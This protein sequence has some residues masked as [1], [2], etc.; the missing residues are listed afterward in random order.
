MKLPQRRSVKPVQRQAKTQF[1]LGDSIPSAKITDL[2]ETGLGVTKVK[3]KTIFVVGAVPGDCAT[4]QITEDTPRYAL[5]KLTHLTSASPHRE[6]PFCALY[7]QCGGCQLQHL[8]IDA[9]RYWK[10]QHLIKM[11][12]KLQPKPS[13]S[14]LDTPN[15]PDRAYR[16]RAKLIL[17]RGWQS[18]Q[19]LLGFRSQQSHQVVDISECPI[20]TSSINQELTTQRHGLL[21][22]APKRNQ[23]LWLSAGDN[24]TLCQ[25][26]EEDQPQSDFYTLMG[27][28]LYFTAKS[29]IQVNQIVNEQLV[30]QALTWLQLTP[31]S[32]VI[33]FFSGIGNFSLPAALQAAAV[34]GI[35]G[36][37]QAVALAHKNANANGITNVRF[38]E[39]NLFVAPDKQ[40][41]WSWPADRAI[42]D[43]GRAG[44]EALCATLGK[45]QLQ[46]LV[47]VSCHPGSLNRD[48]ALLI[49]Q[50]FVIEQAQQF[51][52]FSHT[53]H[54]ESLICLSRCS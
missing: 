48:L 42:L 26:G 40:A 35:E 16:R 31:A 23:T 30:A 47:Y 24:V 38:E 34:L 27:L 14:W 8:N 46:R 41:W 37:S 9:Q 22:H 21:D 13:I 49:Q 12:T 1:K 20:L 28:R 33:D 32:R 29:F 51:D 44:A 18:H 53:K 11:L 45:T 43:P 50:G 19:P 5:A 6:T 54:I 10:Q 36:N 52:M 3:G 17:G 7:H 39:S 15:T 25:L 4:I 2:S